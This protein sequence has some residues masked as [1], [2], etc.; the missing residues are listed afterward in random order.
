MQQGMGPQPGMQ[1][2]QM[3]M[4]HLKG[5]EQWFADAAGMIQQ[6]HPPLLSYLLTMAQAFK[7]L[8]DQVQVVAK[9]SGMA[10]GSP[11]MPP[12]QQT[13]PAAG[14]PNPMQS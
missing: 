14:P 11:E 13:N 6:L 10:Q 4:A 7:Q 5:F 9:R 8:N 2:V 3:L 12:V 1:A